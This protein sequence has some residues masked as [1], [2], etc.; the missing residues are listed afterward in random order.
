VLLFLR[1]LG[2]LVCAAYS[3]IPGYWLLIHPRADYWRAHRSPFRMLLPLWAVMFALVLL[4]TVPFRGFLIYQSNWAWMPAA[5]LFG[6]G[7]WLYKSGGANFSLKQLGGMPE[8]SAAHSGHRLVTT[9]IRAR[10]RHPIYLAHLCEMLAWS[11]GTGLAVCFALMALA[12]ITGAVMIRAEDAELE[13]RFGEEYRAYRA[14]V[15]ALLP[16]LL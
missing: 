13:E 4:G 3:T 10:V 11:M 15:P 1:T 6:V 12:V 5:F 2:W 14:T 8:L 16:R 7:L 9:G